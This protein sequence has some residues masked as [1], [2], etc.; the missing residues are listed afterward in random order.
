MIL[1]NIGGKKGNKK[2]EDGVKV[3]IQ[4]K[5]RTLNFLIKRLKKN[6][7]KNRN[8]KNNKLNGPIQMKNYLIV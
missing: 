5:N 4:K 7:N 1:L 8:K 2:I 3:L 6:S